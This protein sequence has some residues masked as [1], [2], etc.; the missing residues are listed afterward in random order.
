[1][2][3]AL[4]VL[5]LF[6]VALSSVALATP[7]APEPP[8]KKMEKAAAYVVP[9]TDI[10]SP[11]GA[12][13]QE[14]TKE[15]T[16]AK[17]SIKD[18]RHSRQKQR[19]IYQKMQQLLARSHSPTTLDLAQKLLNQI[20]DYP[21]YPYA[22]YQLFKAK[23]D[24]LSLKDVQDYATR[25]P[26]LHLVDALKKEWLEQAKK[27]KNW[28][29][30]LNHRAFL[31]T[32]TASRCLLLEAE[33]KIA[34]KKTAL[35]AQ[36]KKTLQSLWLTGANL[37]PAC[38]SPLS[39]WH[40]DTPMSHELI[41]Q[42][43]LLIFEARNAQLLNALQTQTQD[44]DL[45]H[46]LAQLLQL[47]RHPSQLT[48]QD[49]LFY[50][51]H[52]ENDDSKKRVYLSLFPHFVKT[53]K[54]SAIENR[55][56]PFAPYAI[57]RQD[58]NLT[59]QQTQRWQNALI[60]QLFDSED[61]RLQQWRDKMLIDL[62]DDTLTERR[63]RTAIREKT[64][65]QP[66]LALLSDRAKNKDEWQYWQAKVLE[67]SPQT[68]EKATSILQALR[69][70]RGFYPLLASQEL[71][72]P[73]EPE[74]KVFHAQQASPI[75]QFFADELAQIE[76]LKYVNDSRYLNLAWKTLLDRATFEQKLAL[77]DYAE[78]QGWFDLSV[79]A[80]IQAKA[81]DYLALRLPNAYLDW[82]D[83]H[84]ENKKISRTF[85]MAIAR[86]ESAWKAQ[87][88]SHAN[89]R[90]LMQLLPTTAKQTAQK[91]GLP[92]THENQLFDPFDNIM[93]GTTHLQELYE[94]YGNNRILI[95]AAYNAGVSRVNNWLA[96]TNN[97]LT[98]A[99][100][101]AAIP[102]YETRDYVKNVL[103]YDLYYQQLQHQRQ[104]KFSKE[105]DNRLY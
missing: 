45:K 2:K 79:E 21:L 52:G 67:H 16:E 75:T 23:K 1:M 54:E 63:I 34:E 76:E 49:H 48:H 65:L 12:I 90:G 62:K 9:V 84:L 59:P 61:P 18:K 35:S 104:Q 85:A 39:L 44:P 26:S 8:P 20:T 58:L 74:M 22:Q 99:E 68:Q 19:E 72:L 42:R 5:N 95:A 50:P 33:A 32:D 86:Q 11:Q 43:A 97:R 66:W 3:Q 102:F 7:P 37:P 98:M 28:Q 87:A 17:N 27:Q 13:I 92:Y 55:Q 78:K 38:D 56:D 80:T 29:D 100:F 70:K 93:L 88:T 36:W 101:V 46:W 25:Y 6:T 89:A 15:E 51:V 4:F 96:K 60:S 40:A 31:E 81:W 57:W 10:P 41:K 105:E 14:H 47:L 24:A 103:T 69:K 82:F 71:N 91:Q 94:I 53:L 73:Y 64:P 77:A 83:L 30:M